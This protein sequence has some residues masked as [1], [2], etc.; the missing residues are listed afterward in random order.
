V[1]VGDSQRRGPEEDKYVDCAFEEGRCDCKGED[2][3][4]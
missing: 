1:V 4:V 3:R 2:A